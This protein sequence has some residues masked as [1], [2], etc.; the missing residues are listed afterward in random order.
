MKVVVFTGVGEVEVRTGAQAERVIN[1]LGPGD[2]LGEIALLMGG[3]RSATIRR[4]PIWSP[5]WSS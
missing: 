4:R 3:R 5:R 1:R 2:F